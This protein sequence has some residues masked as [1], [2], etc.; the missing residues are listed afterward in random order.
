MSDLNQTAKTVFYCS[1][2]G[3]RVAGA[4]GIRTGRDNWCRDCW[5]AAHPGQELPEV[6]PPTPRPATATSSGTVRPR[7]PGTRSRSRPRPERLPRDLEGDSTR[8]R[9][10]HSVPDGTRVK[11]VPWL[12][13][14]VVVA[15][16]GAVGLGVAIGLSGAGDGG[17][18]TPPVP[19]PTAG[20][21]RGPVD[22]GPTGDDRPPEPVRDPPSADTR[23]VG[24]RNS[25]ILHRIDC[26]FGTSMSEKN[27]LEFDTPIEALE[28]GYRWCR[29]C[30]PESD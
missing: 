29:N 18:P 7:R 25:Q 16:L 21:D 3:V 28:Q 9:L 11:D 23:C 24:N 8:T 19:G 15:V 4:E 12:L 20:P 14:G 2:C 10:R 6:K 13:I 27:R 30:G 22:P 5:M 1:H 26:T 17:E